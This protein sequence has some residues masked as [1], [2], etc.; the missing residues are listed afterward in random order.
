MQFYRN[1]LNAVQ[2]SENLAQSLFTC[3]N[4]SHFHD[5]YGRFYTQSSYTTVCNRM[6]VVPKKIFL[7]LQFEDYHGKQK[8]FR[9]TQL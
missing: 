3:I 7:K 8:Y 4:F 2:M 1:S 6:S 9:V 5:Q